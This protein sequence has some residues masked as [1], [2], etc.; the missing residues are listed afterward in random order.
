MQAFAEFIVFPALGGFERLVGRLEIRA[1]IGHGVVEPELEEF[2][3]E[4]VVL[5]D[6]FPA[7]GAAVRPTQMEGAIDGIEQIEKVRFRMQRNV[8]ED[9]LLSSLAVSL[10]RKATK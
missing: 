5:A 1:G 9:L 8:R 10:R 7:H 2:V 4:I 3:A 6:V